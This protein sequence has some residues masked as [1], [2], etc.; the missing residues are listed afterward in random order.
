MRLLISAFT[1]AGD[2]ASKRASKEWDLYCTETCKL[3]G[4]R[5]ERTFFLLPYSNQERMQTAR[6]GL[7]VPKCRID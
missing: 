7:S 5:G 4:C 2:P 1:L 3:P 6:R